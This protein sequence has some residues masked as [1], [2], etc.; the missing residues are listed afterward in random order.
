MARTTKPLTNTEVGRAKPRDREYSLVDGKG[1][2][3]RITPA[4][5]KTWLFNYLRPLD[6]KRTNI[7][8]G[9]Y[10]AV[11]LAQARQQRA[12]AREL[13]AQ[14]ID[15][16]RER[17]R[18]ARLAQQANSQTL[19]RVAAAWLEVKRSQ[20]STDHADDIWRSLELHALPSLGAV[21]IG[22]I[23]APD[24][25]TSLKPLAAKGS[26][27]ALQR[28]AHRLREI[29]TFAVNSGMIHSNPLSG[30]GKA[31]ATPKREHFRALKPHQLSELIVALSR[32]NMKRTTR[33][34]IEWQLHTM[35]RP[36]EAAGARWD[37]IDEDSALWVIPLGRMKSKRPH[38]VPLAKQALALLEVIRP[39]SGHREHIF[40]AD[41]DPR[42]H[43]NPSSANMALKRAA[44][45]TT[46]HGLRAL[47]ST[48]LNEAG[49]DPDI[50]ES[51]LAHS[52]GGEV[53]QAYNRAEYLER[54]RVM[55]Q[56]WS[57]H[58]DAAATGNLSMVAN[59]ANIRP[60]GSASMGQKTSP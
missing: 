49:H 47:A 25:I 60:F 30:I 15:P 10:P 5:T 11:S 59:V 27:E 44:A 53:R 45:G 9:Q 51:A 21:P 36:G 33:C 41:R 34:L 48:T 13:L 12:Q 1:L 52:I 2:K 57:D 43:A 29:M 54:R 50:I 46:A 26:L 28:V 18:L 17:E 4:G 6:G 3:L 39:L 38:T 24:A 7:G 14:S 56:W 55:M 20:V 35:V 19:E 16:R 22:Q 23:S 37:E 58:I 8:F 31:F 40:P 42:S 32:G